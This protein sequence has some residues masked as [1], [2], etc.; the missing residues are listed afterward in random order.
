M[1]HVLG[2]LGVE[3]ALVVHGEDG[4]DEITTTGLTYVSELK[5]GIVRDYKI[6]PE[7]YG[8]KRATMKDIGG[9]TIKDNAKIIL[10][11]LRGEKGPKRDIVVLNTAAALYV[12]KVCETIKAGVSLAEDLIDSGKALRKLEELRLP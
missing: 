6:Y 11:I 2:K 4:L 1:A 9:G 3:R 7:D 8:I 10:N 5:D 12:G